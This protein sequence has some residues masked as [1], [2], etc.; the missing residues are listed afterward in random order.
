MVA[1]EFA[2]PLV[3]FLD[4]DVMV[5]ETLQG[6]YERVVD[7][8][9]LFFNSVEVVHSVVVVYIFLHRLESES[10]AYHKLVLLGQVA[11][12]LLEQRFVVFEHFFHLA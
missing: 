9:S 7:A 8:R 6:F 3:D 12:V 1:H 11:V 2:H 4:A 10:G 5:L